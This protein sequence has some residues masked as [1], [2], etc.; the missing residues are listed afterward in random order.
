MRYPDSHSW[1]CKVVHWKT[2]TFPRTLIV[3][4]DWRSWQNGILKPGRRFAVYSRT[5]WITLF[6][7][8]KKDHTYVQRNHD[9]ISLKIRKIVSCSQ[10]YLHYDWRTRRRK[11][12]DLATCWTRW[13]KLKTRSPFENHKRVSGTYDRL[14]QLKR[15]MR[16][17][18]N[19]D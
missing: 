7:L 8:R 17:S 4:C 15:K 14:C 12:I 9:S 1:P 6:V 2:S 16:K 19:Y 18:I 10:L 3:V 5:W 11:K 13:R